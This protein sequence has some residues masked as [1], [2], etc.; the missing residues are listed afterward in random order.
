VL[1]ALSLTLRRPTYH[2]AYNMSNEID[3]RFSDIGA[4]PSGFVPYDFDDLLIRP[5]T[6]RE[7]RLVSRAAQTGQYTNL[8]RAVDQCTDIDA[9]QLT[10]GDFYYVLLWLR[11]NSYPKTPLL[12]NWHCTDMVSI[13]DEGGIT[14]DPDEAVGTQVCD[15]HNSELVHMSTVDIIKLDKDSP[16]IDPRLDYPRAHLLDDIQE[17]LKNPEL[18]QLVRAIQYVKEGNTMQEKLEALEREDDL[19]L[20]D[21]AMGATEKH[22]HGIRETVYLKCRRCGGRHRHVLKIDPLTFFR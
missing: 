15:T 13:N 19:E 21:D 14:T 22:K 3:N 5:F 9:Y 11:V 18:M 16:E 6:I 17:M 4:L 7:L 12:V 20:F 1:I 8:L 2:L 10:I